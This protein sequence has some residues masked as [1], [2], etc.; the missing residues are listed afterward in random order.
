M[1]GQIRIGFT[2]YTV[3]CFMCLDMDITYLYTKAQA[4][5][6]F[7]SARWFTVS[8]LWTCPAHSRDEALAELRQRRNGNA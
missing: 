2:E 7:R 4:E 5:E 1:I 3:C 6:R 8:G